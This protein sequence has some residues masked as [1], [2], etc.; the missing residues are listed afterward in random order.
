MTDIY[1][2]SIRLSLHMAIQFYHLLF[3]TPR[4]WHMQSR[5]SGTSL[6]SSTSQSWRANWL[7]PPASTMKRCVPPLVP[8]DT[9][10]GVQWFPAFWRGLSHLSLSGCGPQT[11]DNI[12]IDSTP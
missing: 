6:C 10:T 5:E 4:V 3:L 11:T 2:Q 9:K 8:V 12:I 1:E 7:T